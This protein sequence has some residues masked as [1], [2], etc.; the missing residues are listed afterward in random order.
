VFPVLCLIQP[1]LLLQVCDAKCM[2]AKPCTW[3]HAA[4]LLLLLLL[5][6]LQERESK[7]LS[8]EGDLA[9]RRADLER[10]QAARMSEAEAAVRRLQVSMHANSI[11]LRLISAGHNQLGCLVCPCCGEYNV[12][13]LGV[14][15]PVQT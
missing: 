9:R 5:L 14:F 15:K 8:A 12:A 2:S 11:C 6:L 4:A 3:L 10:Q 7:V 13:L 1:T